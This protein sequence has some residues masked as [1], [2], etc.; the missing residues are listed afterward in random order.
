MYSVTSP[1]LDMALNILQEESS[2]H[3]GFLLPTLYQLLEKLRRLESSCKMCRPLVDAL[4]D[5]IQKR[6]GEI[7]KDP[8]LIAAAHRVGLKTEEKKKK[9]RLQVISGGDS[10]H[11]ST[12]GQWH[13]SP[14][15][16]APDINVAG[17][18]PG[19]NS[20]GHCVLGQD[21][22][23]VAYWWWSEGPVAPVSGSLASVSAPQGGCGYNVACHHQCVNEDALD[24]STLIDTP[25]ALLTV[26]KDRS[27][28]SSPFYFLKHGCCGERRLGD[29]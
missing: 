25:V 11:R 20:L 18:S 13:S 3:M 15:V 12:K 29:A 7:M 9:L 10:K 28:Q 22:S 17:S 23:P 21:T 8:E 4:R 24:E 14:F 16:E 19:S 5:G 26:V 2:V 1:T 27:S 6:F